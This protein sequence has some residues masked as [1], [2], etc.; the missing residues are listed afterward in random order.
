MNTNSEI[1]KPIVG[2]E[3][4]YEVSNLGRVKSLGNTRK[5]SRFKG[6]VTFMRYEITRHNYHRILL[7]KDGKYKHFYV[8]RL[9]AAAFIP[10]PNNYPIVNH[11]DCNP[12]NNNACNLEWCTHKFNVN[13]AD[14]LQKRAEAFKA[15]NIN[16][17]HSKKSLE[18]KQLLKCNTC[19]KAV[20]Q[21]DCNTGK[22][23]NTFRSIQ[24]AQRTL[25]IS[26]IVAVLKGKRHSAGGYFWAYAE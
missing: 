4:L 18:T 20:I 6:V 19:E 21:I 10:N 11:K 26:H 12:S 14:A 2:Y 24:E 1:W 16:G 9:V 8:H 23:I 25:S 15:S 13:Y 5:C 22:T 17:V 7:R 3:G